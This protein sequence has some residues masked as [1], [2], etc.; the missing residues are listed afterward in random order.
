MGR[1]IV[2]ATM[3]FYGIEHFFFPHNVPGVPL[4]KVT[5]V[6]IP[7]PVV[8]AYLVGIVLVIAGLAVLIGRRVRIAAATA[9]LALLLLVAFFYV[10]IFLMEVHS[11]LAVEGMNYVGDTLLFAAT[12]LLAGFGAS[13]RCRDTSATS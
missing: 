10:P 5:P 1:I 9:G 11:P 4:E 8:I 12:V 3:I 2:G 7:V 6:W 13:S